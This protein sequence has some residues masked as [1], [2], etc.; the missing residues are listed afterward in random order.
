MAPQSELAG[1]PF[2][3][4]TLRTVSRDDGHDTI[5]AREGDRT[6]E[7]VEALLAD[8]SR[9]RENDHVVGADTQTSPRAEPGPERRAFRR[10]PVGPLPELRHVDRVGE[11][12]DPFRP[13]A[14]EH[15][16]RASVPVT[17]TPAARSDDPRHDGS[18]HLLAPARPRALVVTL[19]HEQVR[20]SRCAPR[21][22]GLRGERAPPGDDDDVG[23]LALAPGLCPE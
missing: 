3:P 20:D 7:L 6:Q 21:E 12:A 13:L 15:R 8:E 18:L 10:E 4:R 23:S 9:D 14:P 11:D 16:V 22:S 1:E 5:A 2:E 19:D 17:R